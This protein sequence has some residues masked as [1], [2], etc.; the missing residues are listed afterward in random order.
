MAV[1]LAHDDDGLALAVLV[2]GEAAIAAVLLVVR[3]LLVAAEVGAV[4]LGRLALAAHDAAPQLLRHGLAQLV[5]QHEGR[6]VGHAE[7]AGERQGGLAL[8]LVAEDR[9][10]A[11]VGA[12][13]ELVG[14]EQG[15]RGDGEVAAALAAAEAEGAGEAAALIGV[16]AAALG[17]DRGAVGV[18]PADGAELGFGLGV[19]HAEDLGEAQGLGGTGEKEVLGHRKFSLVRTPY[20]LRYRCQHQILGYDTSS[21][22]PG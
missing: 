18:G 7:I 1:A 22:H 16:Q 14:G 21:P 6:L 3:G 2:H 20:R 8:H 9:D 17:A 11:E 10:G 19:R 5:G 12:E 4:H 15:A 13:R